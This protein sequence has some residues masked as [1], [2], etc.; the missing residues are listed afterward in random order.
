MT[1]RKGFLAFVLTFVRNDFARRE[2]RGLQG[3]CKA[4]QLN[5]F[6]IFCDPI[7]V[8]EV[9]GEYGHRRLSSLAYKEN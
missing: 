8:T 2:Q 9:D 1:A 6:V 7:A 3:F 5:A 4:G